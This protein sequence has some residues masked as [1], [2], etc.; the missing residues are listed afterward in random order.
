MS[1][2]HEPRG[3]SGRDQDPRGESRRD[4]DPRGE[5]RRDADLDGDL[6]SALDHLERPAARPEFRA[7]L[8]ERFLA[9]A[10]AESAASAP[11]SARS[12]SATPPRRRLVLLG[13]AL[14]AAA[15][16]VL[17]LFLTK[18][19]APAWRVHDA[20]SA[21]S[22]VVDGVA[23]RVDDRGL[24]AEALG[25]ARE[26]EVRGGI[27][28][29]CVRDEAWIEI[30]DGTRLSQMKFA[31][32]GP[33]Q[34]KT[35]RGSLAVSTLPAFAGRGMRVLTDDFD[36]QVT[37]TAFAVDVDALGSCL[38][39]LEG[40]VQCRPAGA[41]AGKSVASGQM[42]FAYHDGSAPL[43]GAAH[44]SHLEPLRALRE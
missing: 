26:L 31:A 34:V 42:C 9:G 37:G 28:R 10:A 40:S 15:A 1:G 3:E 41:T 43:W 8:K 30:A 25:S 17:T 36:L 12:A 29:L 24:L 5:S 6:R 2:T 23:L 11:Q 35:D 33:Y 7:A 32:A 18:V 20:S 21:T 38:C 22:V 14:A 13:A 44:A 39:T 19:R 16:V 27:L 4:Q